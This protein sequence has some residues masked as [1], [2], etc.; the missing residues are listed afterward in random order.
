MKFIY[1]H[2]GY[3]REMNR[4]V[5]EQYPK[6]QVVFVDDNPGKTA[7]SYDEARSIGAEEASSFVISFADPALR[8]RKVEQV[9]PTGSHSFLFRRQRR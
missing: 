9:L 8:Q 4:R 3:A 6:E 7:I 1:G 2:G 5:L